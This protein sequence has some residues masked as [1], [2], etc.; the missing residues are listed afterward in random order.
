MCVLMF[1]QPGCWWKMFARNSRIN[2]LF[3][4]RVKT[5]SQTPNSFKSKADRE[6]CSYN[7]SEHRGQMSTPPPPN[8]HT[9]RLMCLA[10]HQ[11]TITVL[12]H[13]VGTM[14]QTWITCM[15]NTCYCKMYFPPFIYLQFESMKNVFIHISPKPKKLTMILHRGQLKLMT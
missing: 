2:L 3:V 14:R 1:V 13:V 8:T 15:C 6:N 11:Q 4:A 7:E 9:H 10:G 12:Q 5:K